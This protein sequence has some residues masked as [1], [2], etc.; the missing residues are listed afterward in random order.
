MK[1]MTPTPIATPTM[2][3]I[4]CIRPSRRKRIAAIHSKGSQLFMRGTGAH[5]LARLRRR[6][7]A[8]R[9]DEVARLQAVAGS[10]PP[11]SPRRPSVTGW[12]IARPSSTAAPTARARVAS[13]TASAGSASVPARRSISMSTDTVMSWRR[14]SGGVGHAELHLDRAALRVDAGVDVDELRG[15][16][17]APDRRRRRR[18]PSGP[19]FEPREVPL[20]DLQHE[21]RLAGRRE[22]HQHLAGLDHVAAL[23]VARDQRAVDGRADGRVAEP[24][25]R[26]LQA[27]ARL[28][29]RGV[30]DR[31]VA[32]GRAAPVSTCL[33]A[34]STWRLR[35]VEVALRSRRAPT[36]R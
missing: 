1:M 10:R 22:H 8:R 31:G 34:A 7:I 24:R 32:A 21:L 28:L 18:A 9:D 6:R 2:M 23:D 4:V 20:V 17:L 26:R 30:R 35:H 12:R 16:A 19:S 36:C 14:Y 29:E 13:R 3:K 27:R 11:P 33:R 15:E 5:A 25:P